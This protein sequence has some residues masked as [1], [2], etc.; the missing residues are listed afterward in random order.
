MSYHF[1]KIFAHLLMIAAVSNFN[2]YQ[3][4]GWDQANIYLFKANSRKIRKKCKNVWS[5]LKFTLNTVEDLRGDFIVNFEHISHLFLVLLLFT[6][7]R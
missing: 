7:N 1:T 5:M 6:M 2:I 4:K 3:L